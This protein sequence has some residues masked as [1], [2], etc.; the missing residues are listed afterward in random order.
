MYLVK[1]KNIPLGV[2][3]QMEAAKQINRFLLIV[4]G[5]VASFFVIDYI[6]APQVGF[7]GNIMNFIY[8]LL[9]KVVM[10]GSQLVLELRG[11]AIN[12]TYDVIW[13]AE[14]KRSVKIGHICLG[15]DMMVIWLALIIGYPGELKS[16]WW[17]ILV[18]WIVIQ[19]AN[20]IRVAALA[21]IIHTKPDQFEVDHHLVFRSVIIALFFVMWYLWL[22][23]F[24]AKPKKNPTDDLA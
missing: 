24:P 23:F 20:I 6:I 17:V 3:Q 18:G 10:Y 5:I 4:L 12:H 1:A 15:L 14:A 7:V 9:L 21:E 19:I 16:K 8:H 11:Y 2:Y 13:I 22:K